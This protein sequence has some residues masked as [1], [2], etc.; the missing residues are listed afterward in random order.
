LNG[1]CDSKPD[2][3]QLEPT[4][5]E[6]RKS[7]YD[8]LLAV[9]FQKRRRRKVKRGQAGMGFE[10]KNLRRFGSGNKP[11]VCVC[12]LVFTTAPSFGATVGRRVMACGPELVVVTPLPSLAVVPLAVRTVTRR[13]STPP[14]S[15]RSAISR[16]LSAFGLR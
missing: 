1:K 8:L 2:A 13:N 12:F 9:S 15:S 4:E 11:E 3:Q 10:P 6:L 7:L 16:T 14:N 5:T